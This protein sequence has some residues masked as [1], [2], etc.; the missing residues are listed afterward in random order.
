LRSLPLIAVTVNPFYPHYRYGTRDYQPAYLDRKQLLSR[1]RESLKVPVFDV[2]QG[3]PEDLAEAI[4]SFGR[5][6]WIK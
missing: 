5:G 1:I 6:V 4:E 2:V 3:G